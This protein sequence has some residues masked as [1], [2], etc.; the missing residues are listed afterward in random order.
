MTDIEISTLVKAGYVI[1]AA[2]GQSERNLSKM[3]DA[4]VSIIP[5]FDPFDHIFVGQDMSMKQ[6]VN[7]LL[8]FKKP[9]DINSTKV[10]SSLSTHH[11]IPKARAL[12]KEIT[13]VLRTGKY[14]TIYMPELAIRIKVEEEYF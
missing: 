1:V 4:F 7:N 5:N 6:M 2:E 10:L 3:S 11:K 14:S 13:E 9:L 12:L 8:N